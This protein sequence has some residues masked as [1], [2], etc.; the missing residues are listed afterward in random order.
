[1]G[2]PLSDRLSRWLTNGAALSL[3]VMMGITVCDVTR[4]NLLDEPILGATEIVQLALVY[5]VFL[6]LPETFLRRSH[7][8]V[9]VADHLFGPRVVHWLNLLSG[10]ASFALLVVMVWTMGATAHDAYEMGDTTSDLAIPLTVFWAPLLVGGSC[11]VLALLVRIG[12]DL[13]TKVG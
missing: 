1:M 11:S 9:D 4:R 6:S 3:I 12:R 10:I 2:P 8:T 7:V 5:V 13:R